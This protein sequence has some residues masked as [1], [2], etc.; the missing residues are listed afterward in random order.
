MRKLTKY[1]Q[2]LIIILNNNLMRNGKK[3]GRDE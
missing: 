1:Q 2:H 3:S